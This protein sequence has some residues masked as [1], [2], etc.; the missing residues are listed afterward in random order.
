MP[1]LKHNIPR[2]AIIGTPLVTT[3]FGFKTVLVVG[4]SAIY[5]F[6][7]MTPGLSSLIIPRSKLLFCILLNILVMLQ[8]VHQDRNRMAMLNNPEQIQDIKVYR[9]KF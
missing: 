3:F 1:F 6:L 7:Y 2:S 8:R 5:G 4:I 9:E